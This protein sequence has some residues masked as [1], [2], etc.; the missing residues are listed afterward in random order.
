MALR[1][2]ML[3][4]C[5]FV[6]MIASSLAQEGTFEVRTLGGEQNYK[7]D[8]KG[9]ELK[10]GVLID[11]TCFQSG[12]CG[13]KD[14]FFETSDSSALVLIF[15]RAN[16]PY[17]E[18]PCFYPFEVTVFAEFRE[19]QL[20]KLYLQTVGQGYD[21]WQLADSIYNF[22]VDTANNTISLTAVLKS[23]NFQTSFLIDYPWLQED[24]EGRWLTGREWYMIID[25]QFPMIEKLRDACLVTVSGHRADSYQTGILPE[26][27]VV[28]SDKCLRLPEI[29]E[30][31]MAADQLNKFE[32]ST[33]IQVLYDE[34]AEDCTIL[35]YRP[36]R[37]RIIDQVD[38]QAEFKG[39]LREFFELE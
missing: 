2:P 39:I 29:S 22:G 12:G 18:F 35:L 7:M 26:Q 10:P 11:S 6:L 38:S 23:I 36:E 31:S 16:L 24:E 14:M 13:R 15:K 20:R 33:G 25:C 3:A 1:I 5:T 4:L 17:V 27:Y 37:T 32:D 28:V 8:I 34:S 9:I 21:R 30:M 19:R